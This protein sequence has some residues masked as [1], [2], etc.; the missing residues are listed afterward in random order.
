MASGRGAAGRLGTPLTLVL[1]TLFSHGGSAQEFDPDNPQPTARKAVKPPPVSMAVSVGR[2]N[3][4]V[5]GLPVGISVVLDNNSGRPISGRIELSD[6][7]RMRTETPI[8]LARGAHKIY[9]LYAP[10]VPPDSLFGRTTTAEVRLIA[11]TSVL[12]RQAVSP[13]FL[14]NELLILSATGDGDGL[15]FLSRENNFVPV[16][17]PRRTIVEHL[18]PSDLPRDWSG[19]RPAQLVVLNGRAWTSMD[20]QQRRALRLWVDDGGRA[21]LAGESTSE[22]RDPDGASLAGVLPRRISSAG[23]LAF[24]TRWGKA[25]FRPSAGGV[26]TVSG[27]TSPGG[28]VLETGPAGPLIVL[29]RRVSGCVLWLGFDPFR[30]GLREWA[31]S[32][33]FWQAAIQTVR[34]ARPELAAATLSDN[35]HARAAAE[36]LPRLPVPPMPVLIGFGVAYAL[37]F[38]PVNIW[39]L[40]RMRRTVRS[41]LF[42]PALALALT[43]LVLAVGQTWGSAR[44]VISTLTLLQTTAGSRSAREACLMGIFSPTNRAFDLALDDTGGRIWDTSTQRAALEEAFPDPGAAGVAAAAAMAG[45]PAGTLFG[46][47]R[48]Q[49]DGLLR[50]RSVALQL[51]SVRT[52]EAHRPADLAGAFECEPAAGEIRSI[53]NGTGLVLDSCYLT[54]GGRVKWIGALPPGKAMRVD[55][56][57][58][59]KPPAGPYGLEARRDVGA[60][61]AGTSQ[62]E[63]TFGK[64]VSQLWNGGPGAFA[65]SDQPM[66]LWLVGRSGGYRGGLEVEGTGLT[67][68]A[69]LILVRLR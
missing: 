6:L 39:V 45:T 66:G 12:A 11:G 30:I 32:A 35:Q 47:P 10:L 16:D 58:W 27:P 17:G 15:Q 52:L 46:W 3:F 55:K 57:A 5:A 33:Q 59:E 69:T 4:A 61:S 28:H 19:Y 64:A 50:W 13:S 1:L 48:G 42:M 24:L 31:G 44:T 9:T 20:D 51:F 7:G 53:R 62:E 26:L 67:N 63:E 43:L 36:A 68:R 23:E 60:E 14:Q 54:S 38:G 2:R 21:I 65:G 56:L 8:E 41:W 40:R 37:V 18:S 29:R 49:V 22:W 25:P 34:R